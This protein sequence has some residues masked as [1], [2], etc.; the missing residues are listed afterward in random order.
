MMM[1]MML[2]LKKRIAKTLM[3]STVLY[4]AETWTL[5]NVDIQ[6]LESFEMW[7]WRRLMSN[8]D[9]IKRF[10]TQWMKTEA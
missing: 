1:M 10:W 3:W 9:P 6:R 2:E 7:I 5:R 4:A 8:T